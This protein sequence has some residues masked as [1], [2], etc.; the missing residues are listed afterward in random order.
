MRQDNFDGPV[1]I[2]S[3]EMVS[4]NDLADLAI[5]LSG[6]NIKIVNVDGQE[7]MDKY[8]FKC[9]TGVRGRTSDNKLYKEKMGA[10]VFYPL[11]R[12]VKKTYEWI[13]KQVN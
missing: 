2:G 1:N 8:G 3:E 7:F 4:I 5:R 6:K 12:G 13:H 10:N 9:P 11:F